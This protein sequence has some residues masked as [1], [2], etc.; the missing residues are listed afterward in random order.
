MFGVSLAIRYR[1]TRQWCGGASGINYFL[2]FDAALG[3]DG[4]P[5]RACCINQWRLALPDID[6]LGVQ[7]NVSLYAHI[8]YG[9]RILLSGYM[10]GMI[11]AKARLHGYTFMGGESNI[12]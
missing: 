10:G 7:L 3:Q 8:K 2:G 4:M 5:Y 12:T 1:V 9:S 6:H 11:A